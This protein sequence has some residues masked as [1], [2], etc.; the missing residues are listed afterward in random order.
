MKLGDNLVEVTGKGGQLSGDEA[1]LKV[2][3]DEESQ[4]EADEFVIEME[5]EEQ[6]DHHG[7][8]DEDGQEGWLT[9]SLIFLLRNSVHL[10]RQ[11]N[12]DKSHKSQ[13]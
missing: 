3:D 13:V 7:E 2:E 12:S 10:A 8:D 5:E 9:L 6:H 1:G 4:M 11:L